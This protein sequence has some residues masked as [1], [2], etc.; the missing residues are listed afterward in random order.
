MRDAGRTPADVSY[1]SSARSRAGRAMIRSI[2]NLTGRHRLLRMAF[3]YEEEVRAGRDF[4]EVM[5]ERYR[6]SLDLGPDGLARIPAEGPLVVVANH[7]FGILDGM[8]MGRILSARRPHFRIIANSVFH[9][10]RELEEVILP[11][12]FAETREA[13]ALN[14]ETRRR[15]LDY[16]AS[17]GAI[18]IFPG[19][20]VSTARTPFGQA[21]DPMWRSFTARLVARSGAQVTPVF[22]HGANSRLF[23]IAS[24]LHATL[25]LALL[26][27]EFGARVGGAVGATVGEPLPAALIRKIAADPAALMDY[28]RDATYALSPWPLAS[29]DYGFEFEPAYAGRRRGERRAGGA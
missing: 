1:A 3:G 16:L 9:R 28:L 8:A 25:R 29:L 6:V 12:D 19:G 23:Q 18:G 22:F 21:M 20:T 11:I 24:H 10:A 15:A 4:W 5:T 27:K 14:V 26:I 17:G 7:P 13:R 2:E